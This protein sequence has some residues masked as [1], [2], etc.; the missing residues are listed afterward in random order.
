ML[1]RKRT[2]VCGRLR[3]DVTMQDTSKDAWF[4][5]ARSG[6]VRDSFCG[7]LYQLLYSLVHAGKVRKFLQRKGWLD[8]V[9][10]H[11]ESRKLLI[12]TCLPRNA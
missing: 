8:L 10:L 2:Q 11:G 1:S 4:R 7:I 3:E 6:A 9:H 5:E 12:L